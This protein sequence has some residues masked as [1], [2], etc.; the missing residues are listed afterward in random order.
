[1]IKVALADVALL[2]DLLKEVKDV[3]NETEMFNTMEEFYRMRKDLSSTLNILSHALYQ[4][5]S[6]NT[7]EAMPLVRKACFEYFKLGGNCVNGPISLLSGLNDNPSTLIYHFF[8]VAFYGVFNQF[9]PFPSPMSI[10][11]SFKMLKSASNIIFPL[12]SGEHMMDLT[13]QV[14]KL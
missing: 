5:F 11:R 1:M 8:S 2:D 14:S 6:S 4:V 7:D 9:Y 13:T 10:W 3:G 12:M